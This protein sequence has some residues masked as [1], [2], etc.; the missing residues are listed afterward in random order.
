[1]TE[2]RRIDP[3]LPES[4]V[5]N[6]TGPDGIHP[7]QRNEELDWLLSP[8]IKA[9]PLHLPES[10]R[11]RTV[12][13]REYVYFLAYDRC[14]TNPNHNRVESLRAAGWDYATT[15]DV[16]MFSRADERQKNEIRSGDRRLMKIP[17]DRWKE[18]RKA[19]LLAS[20]NMIHPRGRG[21]RSVMGSA[22]SLPGQLPVAVVE[23]FAE[24][25]SRG[26]VSDAAMELATGNVTGNASQVPKGR[27]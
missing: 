18:I 3:D 11:I 12:K 5:R 20:I 14:G 6:I 2:P 15:D 24:M 25:R 9:R 7:S 13:N 4:F 21:E 27:V 16:E 23:D 17:I 19:Q 10:G 8:S 26:V 1:M 22:N